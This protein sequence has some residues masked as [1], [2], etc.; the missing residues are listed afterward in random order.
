MAFPMYKEGAFGK[1]KGNF[2][3]MLCSF[4]CYFAVVLPEHRA[5]DALPYDGLGEVFSDM[6]A[7]QTALPSGHRA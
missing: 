5:S 4:R 1:I 3:S 6:T 7:L 2:W